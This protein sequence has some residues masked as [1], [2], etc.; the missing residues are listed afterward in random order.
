MDTLREELDIEPSDNQGRVAQVARERCRE[1]LRARTSFVFN[2]TNIL[3]STRGRWIHLCW[4]YK[5]RLEIVYVGPSFS[6]ILQQNQSRTAAVPEWVIRSLADKCEP[7][8]LLEGHVL[9]LV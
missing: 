8:T 7:P 2:A 5:A 6:Q 3:R 4:D 9:T 1:L